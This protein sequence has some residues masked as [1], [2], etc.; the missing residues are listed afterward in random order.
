MDDKVVIVWTT[1]EKGTA[2]NMVLM[3]AK[4]AKFRAWWK[5]VELVIW[6]ASTKLF[7]DDEDIRKEL[8]ECQKV[9]VVIR[10]CQACARNYGSYDLLVDFG[11]EVVSFG[12]ILTKYIKDGQKMVTF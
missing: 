9:G 3:Y 4:N 6:G 1:G 10:A 7:M 12:P 2:M 11:I 5:E 8:K